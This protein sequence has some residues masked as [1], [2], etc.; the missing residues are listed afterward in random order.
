MSTNKK[1][2]EIVK[3]SNI[4]FYWNDDE[5]IKR[6]EIECERNQLGT[7]SVDFETALNTDD[8]WKHASIRYVGPSLKFPGG[9]KGKSM[10]IKLQNQ[11]GTVDSISFIY[12]L[13]TLK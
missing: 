1:L 10:Q 13:K 2:S 8:N 9:T 3:V 12:R 5:T 7:S 4:Y 6:V 11:K